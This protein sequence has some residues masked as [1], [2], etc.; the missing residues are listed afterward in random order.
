MYY[1]K[2][3]ILDK[4][5]GTLGKIL[6][7]LESLPVLKI[8]ELKPDQTTLVIIDMINAFTREGMLQSS[9]ISE[10]IPAV[11]RIMKLCSRCSI[12]IIAFADSHA[13]D[14]PEFDSYP[15]HAMA[16]TAE[17]ECVDEIKAAGGYTLIPKNSTNGFL[18]EGFQSW[19][20]LNP[21]VE[22]FIVVGDCTDICVQQFAT[23]LKADFN[24][25]NQRKR[26]IVPV[27]AVET[28][29]LEPHN[30]DLMHI[31][32]LFGMMGNGVE[33]FAGIAD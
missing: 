7:I 30:G 28:F 13:A 23:T 16:G 4:S 17:S 2:Q 32:A 14:S 24:R 6:D 31:V 10:I 22:N 27:N 29:D 3:D 15:V 11:V 20:K 26:V 18:E 9:R 21:E 5:T 33:L 25:K 1:R 8:G 12:S 19:L